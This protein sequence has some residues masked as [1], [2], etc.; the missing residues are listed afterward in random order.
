[1]SNSTVSSVWVN[2]DYVIAQVSANVTTSTN[3]TAWYNSSIVFSRG[4]RTYLNAYEIL[5]HNTTNVI[6]DFERSTNLVLVIEEGYTRLY[7]LNMPLLSMRPTNPSTL[8]KNYKFAIQGL[9][10]N[11]YTGRSLV[12]SFSMEFTVVKVDSYLTWPTGLT[13]PSVYYS[14]YPG[15]LFV[16][17]TRYVL[18]P[19]I[20]YGVK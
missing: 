17:L 2:E 1:M 9:S 18:G 12:C 7:R 15:E 16:P 3:G 4:T 19:N 14:N 10:V 5:E 11:T 6:L 8:N 13:L 20:T